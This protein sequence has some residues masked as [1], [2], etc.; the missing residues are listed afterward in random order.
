MAD[1]TNPGK[2]ASLTGRTEM[3]R[4]CAVSA[5]GSFLAYYSL[6]LGFT[7][8]SLLCC[9]GSLGGELAPA[10]S[11]GGKK[12]PGLSADILGFHVTSSFSKTKKYQSL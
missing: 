6:L 3:G 5:G 4:G 2:E 9:V 1:E 11:V 12:L 10:G 7:G 8:P